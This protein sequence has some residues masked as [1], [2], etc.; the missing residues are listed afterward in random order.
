M[1]RAAGASKAT[2]V[3]DQP[4]V[5][6]LVRMLFSWIECK[7]DI[8]LTSNDV[9]RRFDLAISVLQ[10]ILIACPTFFGVTRHDISSPNDILTYTNVWHSSEPKF[11]L[12]EQWRRTRYLSP[13]SSCLTLTLCVRIPSRAPFLVLFLHPNT[14]VSLTSTLF[15]IVTWVFLIL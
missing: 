8:V 4:Q 15:Q 13:Y 6:L 12:S 3:L 1:T 10:A 11:K 2:L 7:F 14:G 5:T 9:T